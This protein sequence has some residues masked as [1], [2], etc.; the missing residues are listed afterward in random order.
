MLS[1]RIL[2]WIGLVSY[3]LYLWHVPVF[4]LFKVYSRDNVSLLVYVFLIVLSF[5]LAAVS[6]YYVEKPFRSEQKV[7]RKVFLGLTTC[8]LCFLVAFG[9]LAHKTNGFPLRVFDSEE[10]F[11]VNTHEVK[12]KPLKEFVDRLPWGFS[13]NKVKALLIGDSYAADVAFMTYFLYGS[14]KLS[15]KLWREDACSASER[16]RSHVAD[17]LPDVIGVA[18]DEGHELQCASK[19]ISFAEDFGVQIFFFGT[20]HFGDNLNWVSRL[21]FN[22]RKSLCQ[23]PNREFA[24]I[25][26]RDRNSLPQANYIS[27][28]DW[29]RSESC[30]FI[31][32]PEGNLISSDRKHL[33]VA[34]VEFL[35]EVGMRSSAY[36]YAIQKAL[37]GRF[38]D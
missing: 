33:T 13:D 1:T 30:V 24:E 10:Q 19:F 28:M 38:L 32:T 34:G 2:V 18:F 9:L 12:V 3:G 22:D 25:D 37:D 8:S 29:V 31:T 20:K 4:S 36:G 26:Q 27:I 6:Y 7:S 16:I 11:S 35:S 17:V 5:G 21:P 14:D 23:R 15:I